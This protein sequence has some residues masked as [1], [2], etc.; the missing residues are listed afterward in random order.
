FQTDCGRSCCNQGQALATMANWVP[1]TPAVPQSRS[2]HPGSWPVPGNSDSQ[3][4]PLPSSVTIT[5]NPH[6]SADNR[7]AY[8]KSSLSQGALE[9]S[10]AKY[11][12]RQRYRRLLSATFQYALRSLPIGVEAPRSQTS[13]SWRLR[14][15]LDI[16]GLM[17]SRSA[18]R[19]CE[20]AGRYGALRSAR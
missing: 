2:A 17:G 4:Q 12:H 11:A 20:L 1:A 16:V 9:P 3:P 13:D 15:H 7:P 6:L 5:Y 18:I 19:H 10:G 14:I 8:L